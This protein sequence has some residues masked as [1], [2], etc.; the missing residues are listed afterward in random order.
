MRSAATFIAG[1]ALGAGATAGSALLLYTGQGFLRTAG[2]LIG[3]S[4]A[5][6]AAGVWVGGGDRAGRAAPTRWLLLVLAF[7]FAAAFAALWNGVETLRATPLGGA[8]AVLLIL[9]EPAYLAGTL[10]VALAARPGNG[11]T[12][13]AAGGAIGGAALGVLVASALLIPH[14]DAPAVFLGTAILLA[15]TGAL[16]SILDPNRSPG[17]RTMDMNDRVALITGVGH[18]EQVGHAVA[19][20]FLA[21]GARVVISSRSGTVAAIAKELGPPDRVVGIPADLLDDAAVESLV[22]GVRERFGRLDVL[23][24]VAGGLTVIR[25]VED[26]TADAW[27]REI[28]RNAD[29][30]FRLTRAA[31]PLLRETRGV[32]VNFASPA[33][34]RAVRNLAAYSAGKAAVVALT[35]ALAIEE[36]DRGVRVNAIAPGMIDTR[37]NREGTDDPDAVRWVSREQIAEVALFLASEAGSGVNGE[38]V[39]V[40][41]SGVS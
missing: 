4:L 14:V 20:R 31:L 34:V 18:P 38:V 25:S 29:T 27:R 21:A 19:Q 40:L 7:A 13:A 39:Q 30:V 22:D 2:S 24:N 26:T 10:L 17:E 41:A 3:L 12:G 23:I 32:V 33:G 11:G 9:A 28:E 5:A 37:Q 8:L 35:R 1:A 36:R 16:H 6:L 15:A